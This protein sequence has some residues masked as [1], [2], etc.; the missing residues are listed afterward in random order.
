MGRC[1][2]ILID[3]VNT[4]G[5]QEPIL[6]VGLYLEAGNEPVAAGQAEDV[7]QQAVHAGFRFVAIGDWNLLPEHPVLLEYCTSGL[8]SCADECRPGELLP[9]TGPMYQGSR[10]R[11]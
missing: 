5:V 10:R 9:A 2:A 6:F 7:L 11:D 1:A 3:C 8:V 4:A